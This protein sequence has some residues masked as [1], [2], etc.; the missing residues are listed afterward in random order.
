MKTT[1]QTEIARVKDFVHRYGIQNIQG[2]TRQEYARRSSMAS[3]EQL[4]STEYEK[5]Y[6]QNH[7]VDYVKIEISE[8]EFLEIIRKITE[9][10]EFMQC[11]SVQEAVHQEMF[12]HRLSGYNR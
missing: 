7:T 11:P 6:L 8:S 12:M 5:N 3:Y 2:V 9:Y 10:D 1:N 4:Y